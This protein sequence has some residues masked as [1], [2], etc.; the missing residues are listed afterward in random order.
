MPFT[1]DALVTG[2]TGC[3]GAALVRSLLADGCRVAVVVRPGRGS[4]ELGA[5]GLTVLDV[6]LHDAGALAAATNSVRPRHVFHLAGAGVNPQSRDL[7]SLVQGNVHTT[8]ALLEVAAVWGC[9]RLVVAGSSA[10][11]GLVGPAPVDAAAPLRP[12]SAYGA[13]KAAGSVLALGLGAAAGIPTVVVR[14]FNVFG[15]GEG[16]WRLL[17]HLAAKLARDQPCDL[18]AGTQ[19]RDFLYVDDAAA[20]LRSGT[21][22]PPGT[23]H[24]ACTGIGRSVRSVVT[25]AAELLGAAPNLLQFGVLPAR[26]DEPAV[27]VGDPASLYAATRWRATSDFDTALATTLHK[28]GGTPGRRSGQDR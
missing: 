16:P 9:E 11:Y 23:T 19:V 25:R 17:P 27:L 15:P 5:A 26:I 20:A 2:A 6:P 4:A 22:A 1:H 3:V 28:L 8:V 21:C 13:T 14:L 12:T 10:E 7:A 18:T 24:N